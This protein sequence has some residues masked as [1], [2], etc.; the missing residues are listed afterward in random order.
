MSMFHS[1]CSGPPLTSIISIPSV[2]SSRP[3]PPSCIASQSA[4]PLTRS[5]LGR[6]PPARIDGVTACER[7]MRVCG[8]VFAVSAEPLK[9]PPGASQCAL[10]AE[11]SYIYSIA[12]GSLDGPR[13]CVLPSLWRGLCGSRCCP[14]K[15]RVWESVTRGSAA[16]S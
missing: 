15:V 3:Q 1:R 7:G 8:S 16:E 6:P 9:S 11:E 2:G 4:G 13:S 10:C 14:Q 5:S 12:H